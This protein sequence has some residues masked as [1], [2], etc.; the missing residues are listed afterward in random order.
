MGHAH[1]DA[2]WLALREPVDHRSRA[3][4]LADRLAAVWRQAGWRR[5]VDLGSGTGSNLRYL[6]PRLPPGQCWTLVDHD[7]HLLGRIEMPGA[8]VVDTVTKVGD[9]G[10]VGLAA[11]ANADVVTGSAVL[12]LVS[13]A[14]VRQLAE[15]CCAVSCAVHFALSYDGT[16]AWTGSQAAADPA[17]DDRIRQLVNTHQRRDKGLGPA[18]GREGAVRLRSLL[19]ARGFTAFLEASPWRLGPGDRTLIAA[20][21]QGWAAA[22]VEV[23]SADRLLVETWAE[24]RLHAQSAPDAGLTVGHVDLLAFP[25]GM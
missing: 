21:V 10:D 1:F 22:A 13:D 14:W 7:P 5:I 19:A 20:L 16:I 17:T 12:D 15:V 6:A 8:G 25:P 11:A 3:H 24:R 2:D 4:G 9:L 18:L 23:C